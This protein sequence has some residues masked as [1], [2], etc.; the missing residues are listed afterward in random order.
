VSKPQVSLLSQDE[1]GAI[2]NASLEVLESTGIKVGSKKALDILKEAGAGVDYGEKH[3]AI[4]RSLVEEA[5]KRAPKTIRYCAR[6]PR[7]DV[8]LNKKETHFI[9]DG[10]D[11][12]FIRDW[13]TGERRVS[14]KEDLA[15]WVR[16]S[17]YLSNVHFIWVTLAANDVPAEMRSLIQL[18]TTLNNT[19]KHVEYEAHSAKEARYMIEIASAIVGGKEELRKRPIISAVQCPVS[20]LVF[21]SGSIEASM[22]FAEAGIPVVYMDMPLVMETSPATLEGTLVIVNAENLAG[23]VISEFTVSGAPVVYSTTAS[24]A[25]PSSGSVTECSRAGLLCIASIQIAH[26]YGLPCEI[27]GFGSMSKTLDAQSGYET[28][29]GI[30]QSMG[31]DIVCGLGDLEAGFCVSPAKLVIDNEIIE[32]ALNFARGLEVNDDT[33]AVD[34]IH[35]VGPGGHFLAEK[36]TLKHYK[37]LGYPQLAD[38]NTFEAWRKKGSK[39][40]DEVAREKVKAILA[41][42]KPMPIPEEIRKEISRILKRAEAE[43]V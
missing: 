21:E 7:Y 19:G 28:A 20:P 24:V 6:D 3:V 41:T 16:V 35:R 29:M 33:L 26:Y 43:L 31:A 5:L 37:E 11:I 34:V 38:M 12:P 30:D 25:D 14:T 23:L 4:P 13:D 10:F 9:T 42:H 8:L 15:R 2:H 40:I 32:G 27:G 36:H 18:V 17:D 39:T 22:E 1:I